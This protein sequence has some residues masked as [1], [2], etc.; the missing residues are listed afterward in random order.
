[1]SRAAGLRRRLV[2][3]A[4]GAAAARVWGRDLQDAIVFVGVGQSG[5]WTTEMALANS[6]N[7]GRLVLLAPFPVAGA[8]PCP[9]PCPFTGAEI[10]ANGSLEI[11]PE[12]IQMITHTT[13]TTVYVSPDPMGPLPSARARVLNASNPVQAM[14]IPG[15]RLSTILAANPDT[16]SFPG[17]SRGETVR[18]NLILANIQRF[19]EDTGPDVTLRIEAFSA[20]GD[21][22]GASELTL[23]YAESRFLVDVLLSPLH[24][25]LFPVARSV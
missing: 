11:D 12:A 16:L 10:V 18:T 7:V 9:D 4:L 21:P 20:E 22:L 24:W 23:A 3:A 25:R 5:T 17:A 15:I 8:G 13:V 19:G 14:E 1:M 2:V 6:E